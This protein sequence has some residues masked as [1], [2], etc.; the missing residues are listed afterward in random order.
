LR[1]FRLLALDERLVIIS[2]DDGKLFVAT[3][4]QEGELAI[5]QFS[6][7]GAHSLPIV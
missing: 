7:T 2:G 4:D 6:D 3:F 5:K 1:A